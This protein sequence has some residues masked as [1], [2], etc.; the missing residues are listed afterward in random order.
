MDIARLQ[1][2]SAFFGAG[3]QQLYK[4][5][6]SAYDRN[7][8]RRGQRSDP[9]PF[10]WGFEWVRPWAPWDEKASHDPHQRLAELSRSIVQDSDAFFGYTAPAVFQLAGRVLRFA[11]PVV[12][13][14]PENNT[15]W[16]EWFPARRANGRAVL[17]LPHWNARPAS[18]TW[19][20]RLLNLF[21][22]SALV[23]ALP[24]HGR[25]R[26]SGAC[27]AEYVVSANIGRTIACARQA[28]IDA[29]CSVD[30]LEQQG[31]TRIAMAGTSLGSG[32]S[33]LTSAHEPRLRVNVFNQ[34]SSTMSDVVWMSLR[35][36]RRQL[37]PHLSQE[38]LREVWSPI[39]AISYF[40]R[41]SRHSK[42]SLLVCGRYDELFPRVCTREVIDAF[43]ARALPHR[44]VELPCGHYTMA[45]PPYCLAAAWHIAT[46]LREEL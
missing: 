22:L 14:W 33:F 37:E 5:S 19:F 21:G 44:V 7:A 46:F 40:D 1:T 12:T 36:L 10:S 32:Y 29:R 25:R 18:Y 35:T 45:W 31:H 27:G 34:C 15:V 24:C 30:W 20:C 16:A 3:W 39:H 11:S 26:P 41:F 17:V 38:A 8:A 9:T 28:V 42:V 13:P 2:E 6:I 4:R 43:R 23:M